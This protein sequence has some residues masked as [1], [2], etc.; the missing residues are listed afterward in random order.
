MFA[1]ASE[2]ADPRGEELYFRGVLLPRLSQDGK[3]APFVNAIYHLYSP[4]RIPG[5]LVA[6]IP[7]W[8]WIMLETQHLFR[9]G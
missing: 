7:F 8:I 4:W 2:L 6:M 3:W 1:C 5:I 9:P